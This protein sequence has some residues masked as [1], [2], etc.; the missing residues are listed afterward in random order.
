VAGDCSLTDPGVACSLDVECETGLCSDGVCCVAACTDLCTSCAASSDGTC[1]AAPAGSDLHG[2]CG[3]GSC[4]GSGAC[5]VGG[6][7]W[8]RGWGDNGVQFV[9]DVAVSPLDGSVV[10]VG[11]FNGSIFIDSAPQ[12]ATGDD[13][14]VVKLDKDG[15][16]LWHRVWG[17][18]TTLARAYGVA[19]DLG[20]NVYV[21]GEVDGTV[22]FGGGNRVSTNSDVV[23][24]KLN[25]AGAHQFSALYGSG[26]NQGP[27]AMR[28]NAL[29]QLVIVGRYASSATMFGANAMPFAANNVIGNLFLL[30]VDGANAAVLAATGFDASYDQLAVGLSVGPNNTFAIG[31]WNTGSLDFGGGASV[32][33][34]QE[35]DMFAAVFQTNHAHVWSMGLGNDGDQ[36]PEAVALDATGQLYLAGGFLGGVDFGG[37]VVTPAGGRDAFVARY[38]AAGAFV[39]VDRYGNAGS[40]RI[41]DLAIDAS[42]SLLL[43]GLFDGQID[44]G[45]NL[46]QAS[47]MDDM[48]VAKLAAD[49]THLWSYKYGVGGIERGRTI[50]TDPDPLSGVVYVG[51]RYSGTPDFGSGPLLSPGG[52]GDRGT[53]GMKLAR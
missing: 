51:G 41:N 30:T 7:L 39:A 50:G 12:T 34:T 43:T 36:Q 53:F 10:F 49:G 23:V 45:N 5:A 33:T 22:D 25:A 27:S 26:G 8:S 32:S 46:L 6:H 9:T 14:F 52:G 48:F 24:V 21:T 1:A 11:Y 4:D 18:T 47:G 29:G 3:A 17:N 2:D 42:G 19:V 20:G 31:G 15:N 37:G 40:E 28:L 16:Y 35:R 44:F 38:D 13:M